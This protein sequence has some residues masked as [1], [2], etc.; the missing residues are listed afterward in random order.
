[1]LNA[2][3]IFK[4]PLHFYCG[5]VFFTVL[6]LSL[7]V[8]W[9]QYPLQY[10]SN[11][12]IT[13][14]GTA[15]LVEDYANPPLSSLMGEHAYPPPID[16]KGMLARV[17]TLRSE[18]ANTALASTRFFVAD[19]NSNLYTLDKASKKF[20]PYITFPEIFPKYATDRFGSGVS[21]IVFDPNYAKNGKFYT[22]HVEDP[23][24]PGSAKPT[25]AHIPSLNL[26][27]Y[28]TTSV[29]KPPAGDDQN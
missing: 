16:Y 29:V 8:V 28:A 9:A 5:I 12:Q 2:Q 7:P 23:G 11:S 26:D 3:N 14:D 15:I 1:M 17:N 25:N 4:Q 24:K 13:K 21:A 10:P 19:M 22:V 18:P 20:I 6:L 27:G